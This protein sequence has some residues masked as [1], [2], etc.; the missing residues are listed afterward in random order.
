M[1]FKEKQGVNYEVH[2]KEHNLEEEI[3]YCEACDKEF[4]SEK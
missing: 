3:Y 2:H 1:Y 4:K